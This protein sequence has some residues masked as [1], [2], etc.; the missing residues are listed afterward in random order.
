[1]A[2]NACRGSCRTD[3]GGLG[4]IESIAY[5]RSRSGVEGCRDSHR[6]EVTVGIP[7]LVGSVATCPAWVIVRSRAADHEDTAHRHGADELTHGVD[8]GAIAALLVSTPYLAAGRQ[9]S[10]LGDP[11]QLEREVAVRSFATPGCAAVRHGSVP[12][13]VGAP[14]RTSGAPSLE[15]SAVRSSD[16]CCE[17]ISA[18][19]RAS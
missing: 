11:N 2:A 5:G 16:W 9:R 8:G 3:L 13:L 14:S 7:R 1:M 6:V 15:A 4:G 12:S 17:S 18:A 10:E 19:T